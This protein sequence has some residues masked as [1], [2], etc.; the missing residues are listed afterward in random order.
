MIWPVYVNFTLNEWK[1]EILDYAFQAKQSSPLT[2]MI[3]SISKEPSLHGDAFVFKNGI[4]EHKT[5]F[6]KE[7]ILVYEI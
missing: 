1:K 6:D 4:V 7:I 5:D 2:L 3:N